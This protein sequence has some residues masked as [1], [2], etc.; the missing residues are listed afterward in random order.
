[1]IGVGELLL[2]LVAFLFAGGLAPRLAKWIFFRRATGTKQVLW[3]LASWLQGRGERPPDASGPRGSSD[4]S[5][6][7][8][9]GRDDG[10]RSTRA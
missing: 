5:A 6:E 4:G 9:E 8:D 10:G 1:M 7:S 2:L 3:S